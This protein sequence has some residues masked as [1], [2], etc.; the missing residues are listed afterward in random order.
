M[1]LRRA[2]NRKKGVISQL[3]ELGETIGRHNLFVLASSISYYTVL[4]LAPTLLILVAVASMLGEDIQEAAIDQAGNLAPEVSGTL[5][6]VFSNLN[7]Q[8]NLGSI[9]GIVG[10]ISILFTASLIFAQLRHALDVIY[11]DYN[12]H[13]SKSVWQLVKERIFLMLV[14]VVM[15]T[16]FVASLF[17][18][19]IF[20]FFLG[21]HLE[22]TFVY[23][24]LPQ[25]VNF[26]IFFVLFLGFYYMTPT[27]KQRVKECAKMAVLTSV[28]FLIGKF[29]ISAYMTNIAAGSVY[30]AA[31]ALFVFLLWAYYSA[32]TLFLSV[33]I[34]EFLRKKGYVKSHRKLV[35][36]KSF[37]LNYFFR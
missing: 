31:G 18:R 3:K 5:E 28:F 19:P 32:L 13:A 6:L 8:V 22:G 15:S 10:V 9:S 33:E 37:S 20:H 21:D 27:R 1:N 23:Q 30:G 26:L 24:Y 16:I 25:V 12:P 14:V 4:G 2:L 29:G 7:E 17:V 11:G 34:F 35:E 36:G